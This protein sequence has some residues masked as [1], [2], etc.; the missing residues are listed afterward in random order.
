MSTL[1]VPREEQ[2]GELRVAATPETVKRLVKE[3]FEV[4]VAAGAGEAASFTDADYEAAGARLAPPG[5]WP[6]ADVVLKVAAPSPREV[7]G[8]RADALLVAFLAPQKNLDTVQALA[9]RR[10]SALA[11]ELVPR[12]TRA[13]PM[14]ALSSQASIG[15]YKAVLVAAARLGKYF[16][17]L[18]TAAGTI[19]PAKVVIMGAGVAGLQAIATAKRLGA[20]VEV[21][22]IRPAVKEQV[23]SLGGKFIELPMQESGEGAGGYAKEM[24]EEFLRQQR[25]IVTR[26]V[27]AA[28]VVI[29]TAQVPGKRAPLLL[30]RAM[31]EGMRRG[32]VVV[33]LAVDSGGNCELSQPDRE[34]THDG[35]HVLG[36]TNL[37]ASMPEDASTLYARNVLSL[38]LSISKGGQVTLDLGDEVVAATLLTHAGEI[39]H[40]PTAAAVAATAK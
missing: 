32:A 13:Q 4:Q 25:E 37:P 28:D 16:P 18:M 26:H 39:R 5:A 22:D 38:L 20:Q 31:V 29:T 6:A 11:M 3:G 2:A 12:I 8:L 24:G 17:L 15:G 21:S 23:Q 33:D 27:A 35:V 30:T 10:V 19:R 34:V 40:A 1:F 14:D 7:A 36:F 9:E